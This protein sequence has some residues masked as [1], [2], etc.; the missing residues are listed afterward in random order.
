[1]SASNYI[2]TYEDIIKCR[3]KTTGIVECNYEVDG[4]KFRLVD[5]GGQRNGKLQKHLD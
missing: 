3:V 4:V 5:V 1:M 2:P